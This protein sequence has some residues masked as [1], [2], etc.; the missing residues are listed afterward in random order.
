MHDDRVKKSNKARWAS[1][2]TLYVKMA[3]FAQFNVLII[4]QYNVCIYLN[5]IQLAYL[6]DVWSKEN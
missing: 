6:S 1:K 3:N 2:E 4:Y 5:A